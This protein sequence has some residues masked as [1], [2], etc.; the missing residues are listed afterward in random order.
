MEKIYPENIYKVELNDLDEKISNLFF[1]LRAKRKTEGITIDEERFLSV[2][3]LREELMQMNS[4][5]TSDEHVSSFGHFLK[6]YLSALK[7]KQ[8]PFA[9]EL[10]ISEGYLSKIIHDQKSPTTEFLIKLGIHSNHLLDT[11]NLMKLVFKNEIKKMGEKNV[12]SI[13]KNNSLMQVIRQ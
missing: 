6:A 4:D 11:R 3:K 5:E 7:M 1:K 8:K 12:K 10:S 13:F 9:A 2:I